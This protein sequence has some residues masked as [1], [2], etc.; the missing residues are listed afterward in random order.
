MHHV[1]VA[2]LDQDVGHRF[3]ERVALRDG[4]EVLLALAV[5]GGD[6]G[7]LAEPFRAGQHRARALASILT[8]NRAMT[9]SNRPTWSAE[10]RGAPSMNRS[11]T[12]VRISIRRELEP[13]VSV[14]SSSS[15]R[16][17]VPFMRHAATPLNFR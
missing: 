10:K 12:A 16:D 13:E 4:V 6:K 3:A 8:I 14:V 9:S 11:V 15:S 5:G 7:V 2:A 1:A 17:K